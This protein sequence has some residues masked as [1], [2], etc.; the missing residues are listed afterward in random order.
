MITTLRTETESDY[1]AV[2]ELTR[3]AFWNLYIPGCD[4]HYLAHILR[5]HPDFIKEFDFVVECSGKVIGS[6]MYTRS[7][8]ENEK[9]EKTETATFGPVSVLPGYQRNGVG[10]MLIRHTV[11]LAREKGYPA[12]II[13]GDPHNYCKH[14]FK[15]GK[16]YNISANDGSF[17]LGLLV[18]ELKKGFFEGHSWKFY[19]SPA[20]EFDKTAAEEFDKRF[21]PKVKGHKPSQDL[22]SMQCRAHL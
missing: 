15:N 18:L 11:R 1:R 4:E 19:N 8:V 2:E 7:Y 9:G 22:F 20:Y 17:P 6:I 5:D 3:E 12:V 13:Y 21:D 14:G 10:A 16:D